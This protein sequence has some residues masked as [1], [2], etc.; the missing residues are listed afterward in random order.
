MI[1]ANIPDDASQEYLLATIE[2][3]LEE[4]IIPTFSNQKLVL[5]SPAL[6]PNLK[7]QLH[8][9]QKNNE[10]FLITFEN[11]ELCLFWKDQVINFAKRGTRLKNRIKEKWGLGLLSFLM[12]VTTAIPF[13]TVYQLNQASTPF[14]SAC[15]PRFV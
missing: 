13:L 2:P 15:L 12:L 7:E 6:T 11:N 5:F 1:L 3:L 10:L 14:L 9:L 8:L 4:P